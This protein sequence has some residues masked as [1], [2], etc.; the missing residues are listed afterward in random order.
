MNRDLDDVERRMATKQTKK[1]P[2]ILSF[3]NSPPM[4]SVTTSN[5]IYKILRTGDDR[6]Q[7]IM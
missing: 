6:L 3:E 2:K 4:A 1:F 7:L 5:D